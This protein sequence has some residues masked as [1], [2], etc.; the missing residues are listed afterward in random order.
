MRQAQSA[1]PADQ[2]PGPP[3]VAP[4]EPT[5]RERQRQATLEEIVAVARDLLTDPSGLSL[6]AVAQ[7]MGITAPA[8]Y[9]YVASYQDLVRLAAA[10]VDAETAKLLVA[11]RDSQPDDDPAAQI[12]CVA[13]AFRRWALGHREEF[14]LVFTNPATAHAEHPHDIPD[15]QTGLV[16]TELLARLWEKYRFPV[17]GPDDLDPAVVEALADPVM[18][19]EA[20]RIPDS[21]RGVLWVFIRSWVACYG[22]VTMEVFGHCDPRIIESGALFREML[23]SQ[24]EML[25]I[26]AELPRLQPL[27]DL[28]LSR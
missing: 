5:R 2:P 8:L 14:G 20:G 28:E 12:L 6:R 25:G 4:A 24:S 10:H 17:P 3:V 22:T 9:R 1:D 18:P 27:I 15:A 13:F 23:V 26:T 11:A 19:L 16:F 21:A 7:R